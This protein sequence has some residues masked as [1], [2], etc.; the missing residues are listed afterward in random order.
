MASQRRKVAKRVAEHSPLIP[1]LA[2]IV[3]E[4]AIEPPPPEVETRD[5]SVAMRTAS[6]RYCMRV[7]GRFKQTV[8]WLP[9]LR[10]A[11]NRAFVAIRTCWGGLDR[12]LDRN[13]PVQDE[14]CKQSFMDTCLE[15]EKLMAAHW[16]KKGRRPINGTRAFERALARVNL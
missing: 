12:I 16:R 3:A 1:D 5:V 8:T 2:N 14:L 7:I 13:D 9:Y 10:W 15:I 6:R 4:Y 11:E